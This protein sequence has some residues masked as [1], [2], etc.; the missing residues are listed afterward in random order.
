MLFRSVGRITLTPGSPVELKPG[1]YHLMLMGLVRPLVRG[2][3]IS[4]TLSFENAGPV[5]VEVPVA[6]N[7]P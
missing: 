6:D 1:G 7:A 2:E 5:S 4:V 3:T